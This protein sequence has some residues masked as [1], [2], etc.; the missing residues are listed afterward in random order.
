ML[1]GQRIKFWAGLIVMAL[2]DSVENA[3][4]SGKI[5]IKFLYQEIHELG[6]VDH[7]PKLSRLVRD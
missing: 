4:Q 3:A 5:K 7:K 1:E 2:K 6:L